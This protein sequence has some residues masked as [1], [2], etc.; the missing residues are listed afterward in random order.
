MPGFPQGDKR[1]PTC[2]NYGCS[3]VLEGDHVSSLAGIPVD[4]RGQSGVLEHAV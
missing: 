2:N 1:L 4:P 3:A